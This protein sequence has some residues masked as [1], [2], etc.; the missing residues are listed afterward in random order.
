MEGKYYLYLAQAGGLFLGVY[1]YIKN[2]WSLLILALILFA[3][4]TNVYFNENILNPLHE[5]REN[6]KIFK[7]RFEFID[8]FNSIEKKA[9]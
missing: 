1:S 7:D 5:I 9:G 8:K 2:Q 4:S 3:I 6:Q